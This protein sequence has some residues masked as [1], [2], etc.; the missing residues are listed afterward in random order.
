MFDVF[1]EGA[2]EGFGTA[3]T[4]LPA[5]IGLM[6]AIGMFKASGALD[7]LTAALRPVASLAQVPPEVVPLAIVRPISGS[8]AL[9]VF[10]DI[11]K[12][13]GPDSLIGQVASVMQG[14][15]ETTFYTIAVYYGV[16]KVSRTRHT[17]V[18]SLTGDLTGFLMSALTVQLM[19]H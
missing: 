10:Q 18:S 17:L 4:V 9:A 1:I 16:T 5:L 2:K 19:L 6:T 3:A 7:M 8:G 13:Y 15:T 14:S 12:T 11:L